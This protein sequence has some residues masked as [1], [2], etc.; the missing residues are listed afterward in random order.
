MKYE[1][2]WLPQSGSFI[3]RFQVEMELENVTY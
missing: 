3:R 1:F 2:Q